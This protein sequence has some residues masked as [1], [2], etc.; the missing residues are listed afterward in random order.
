[1]GKH[2]KTATQEGW[3][4]WERPNL[5]FP[6]YNEK[7]FS[8]WKPI[9]LIASSATVL[10]CVSFHVFNYG[11]MFTAFF[12]FLGTLIPF[13]IVSRGN[14][15]TLIKKLRLG[16][17]PLI[18]VTLILYYVYTMLV[19]GVLFMLL[20]M[21]GQGNAAD[22]ETKDALFYVLMFIQLVGEEL[23]KINFFL[24]LL[25]LFFG[26]WDDRKKSI[27]AATFI[28]L[29]SFGL[30]HLPAYGGQVLQVLLIQGF[31]SVFNM[32]CYLKTKN[33]VVSYVM[34]VLTDTLGFIM[35]VA[36]AD[37]VLFLI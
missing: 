8:I 12:V 20:G 25:T 4:G 9:L 2:A 37:L 23:I 31:G 28:T 11:R 17:V 27:V 14:V 34:H 21:S 26:F 16:D 36:G 24:G 18:L 13:L 29:I 35:T 1:M 5:D 22:S 7:D 30:A 6:F 33:V 10:L 15:G 3:F 19:A 32:F